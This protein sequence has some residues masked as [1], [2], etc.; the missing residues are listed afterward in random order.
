VTPNS[1][2]LG[3]LIGQGQKWIGKA[4]SQSA[5]EHVVLFSSPMSIVEGYWPRVRERPF[6]P[7]GCEGLEIYRI[8]GITPQQVIVLV[9]EARSHIGELYNV[10][11]IA[12][13]G[14][15]QLGHA[16]YCSQGLWQW[17][18]ALFIALCK[19]DDLEGPDD[20]AASPL[21][22]RIT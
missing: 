8:K 7:T 3:K 15:V 14:L 19:W 1:S 4:P 10:V 13:F 22:E 21:L 18:T 2:W 5:Y 20:V 16:V 11:G 9:N 12:T 6:D 17:C